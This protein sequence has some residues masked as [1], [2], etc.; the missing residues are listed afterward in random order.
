MCGGEVVM[1]QTFQFQHFAASVMTPGRVFVAEDARAHTASALRRWGDLKIL[2]RCVAVGALRQVVVI[3]V[4]VTFPCFR[5]FFA[6][7]TKMCPVPLPCR[8]ADSARV[9]TAIVRFNVVTFKTPVDVVQPLVAE[10]QSLFIVLV[11]ILSAAHLLVEAATK[12]ETLG[13]VHG[14]G[15]S[16]P[17]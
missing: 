3:D 14:V 10:N 6:P 2:C 1:N 15:P 9:L 12:D 13:D 4:G 17:S 16:P 5:F 8:A 11:G 7:A